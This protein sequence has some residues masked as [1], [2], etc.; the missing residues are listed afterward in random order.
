MIGALDGF[1]VVAE[2]AS[3][4]LALDAARSARPQL[5][6]IEPELSGCGGW[7]VIQ[8]IQ[9][10]RL[11]CVVVALGRRADG[12]LAQTVGAQIY[13]QMGTAPRDLLRALEAAISV[14][15]TPGSAAEAEHDLLADAHPVL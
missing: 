5:A 13:V 7:W 11:A 2:A 12:I 15:A 8:Q 4:E 3:D 6:L 14:R 9:A 1:H 10:E